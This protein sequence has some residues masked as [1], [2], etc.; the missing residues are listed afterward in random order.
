MSAIVHSQS[1]AVDESSF[2]Y[3]DLD[4]QPV[5]YLSHFVMDVNWSFLHSLSSQE[6]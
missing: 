1:I 5:S 6:M 2:A 4:L 3:V